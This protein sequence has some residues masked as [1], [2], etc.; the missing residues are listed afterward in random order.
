MEGRQSI[1]RE[2][3]VTNKC[4]INSNFIPQKWTKFNVECKKW[5]FHLY[6]WKTWRRFRTISGHFKLILHRC[7][8]RFQKL[9]LLFISGSFPYL[10]SRLSL[11]ISSKGFK[12]RGV[13]RAV[14]VPSLVPC[15]SV[16]LEFA[17]APLNVRIYLQ[18]L[19]QKGPDQRGLDWTHP[20]WRQWS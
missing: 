14:L 5:S 7:S 13:R 2:H 12:Y 11:Q 17:T 8:I 3:F 4:S 9:S 6:V 1:R 19:G 10:K 20:V 15:N 18:F 16:S